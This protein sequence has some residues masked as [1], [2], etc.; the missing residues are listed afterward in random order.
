LIDRRKG[1]RVAVTTLDA[2]GLAKCRMIKIDV[3][4]MERDVILGAAETIRR[5]SPY[6]YVENDRRPKTDGLVRTVAEL[7][8]ELYP[9]KP[10]LYNPENF[11]GNPDNI[12]GG[13]ISSNLLCVP[14]S[15]G[16]VIEGSVRLVPPDAVEP[17]TTEQARNT[18]RP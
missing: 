15:S 17:T 14:R 7:G 9:H 16:V 1:D 5:T 18:V 12:F 11:L 3:E 10:P 13:I 4:G 8:Y 6:L 2:L